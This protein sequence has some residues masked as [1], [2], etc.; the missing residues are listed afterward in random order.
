VWNIE[1]QTGVLVGMLQGLA[2]M[3]PLG[4]GLGSEKPIGA[5]L[6]QFAVVRRNC[7]PEAAGS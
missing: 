7:R 4:G 1:E 3:T 5:L 2:K 6:F